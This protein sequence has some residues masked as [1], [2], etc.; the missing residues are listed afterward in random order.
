MSSTMRL[1]LVSTPRSGNTWLRGLLAGA[2]R[3]E[4]RA[5]HDPADLDW[6]SLPARCIVQVHWPRS[7]AFLQLLASS[8]F[9]PVVISRH[10]LDVLV[11]ILH[12]CSHTPETKMWLLGMAGDETAIH[13]AG[14]FD[15]AFTD[16]ATGPRAQ[17]LLSV[18]PDW[19][20]D[21][22]G[23]KFRYEDLVAATAPVLVQ[24]SEGLGPFVEDV[25]AVI[26]SQS[27]QSLRA[28][29]VNE[30]FWQGTP[31]LWKRLLTQVQ[32]ESIARVH[33]GVLMRLGYDL[34]Q[35]QW[36]SEEQV[37]SAWATLASPRQPHQQR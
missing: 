6:P 34:D 23:I 33:Q 18:T 27:L 31:G 11:S 20:C 19:W 29:S 17:A 30:H 3:L 7:E 37:A 15:Q 25:A 1:A 10:P 4:Q 8:G 5:V 22:E 13:G 32:A 16:Y 36:P 14:P 2:Y 9:R 28:T 21:D 35:P 26:S 24:A 12:F